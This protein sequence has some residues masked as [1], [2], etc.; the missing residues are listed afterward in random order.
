MSLLK[1][2]SRFRAVKSLNSILGAMQIV[3]T[4][5]LQKMREKESSVKAYLSP[6]EALLSTHQPETKTTGKSLVV[7]S[8]NRGLCGP[9]SSGVVSLAE[10]FIR[11]NEKTDV[12]LLGRR[13]CDIYNSKNRR[14]EPAETEL[15]EKPTYEQVVRYFRRVFNPQTEMFVAYNMYRGG[16]N[17]SPKIIR[18][19]PISLELSGKNP[20]DD[21]LLEPD[22]ESFF[23]ALY[24]H[25]LETKFYELVMSSQLA[26]LASRL[27][28]LNGA[29]ANS[30]DL[31]DALQIKINKTRQAA[32]TR[33]LTEL[34][35]SAETLRRDE[36]E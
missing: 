12:V 21:Y 5:R 22:E 20:A 32:I 19:Y 18:L 35:A 28:V 1:L 24:N 9:F 15:V 7:I 26:E 25:Y 8:S 27:M 16:V 6:I 11:T 4:V 31:L 17:Y 2:R 23:A 14:Q 36:D 29:V 34:V 10:E 33:D 13:G 3:S 30:K